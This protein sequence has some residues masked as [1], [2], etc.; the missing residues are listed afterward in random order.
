MQRS[1][2]HLARIED[3]AREAIGDAALKDV[4]EELI[5]TMGDETQK[6]TASRR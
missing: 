1:N 5:G 6:L 3:D 4:L 2:A